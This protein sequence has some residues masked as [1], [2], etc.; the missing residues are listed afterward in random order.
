MEEFFDIEAAP[1]STEVKKSRKRKT[2]ADGSDTA[3]ESVVQAPVEVSPVEPVVELD[4]EPA[5]ESTVE[6][7]TDSGASESAES[8]SNHTETTTSKIV[9]IT[10][11]RI[12]MYKSSASNTP[13]RFVC[14]KLAVVSEPSRGKVRVC[15]Y[16]IY[17]E[18]TNVFGWISESFLNV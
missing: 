6:S 2:K 8:N 12:P 7:I 13:H 4:V 14:G 9:E 18:P 11:R 3:I 17:D 15:C 1:E 16:N 10:G 5:V